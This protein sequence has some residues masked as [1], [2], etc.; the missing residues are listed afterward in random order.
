MRN[1]WMLA[2]A[3][4]LLFTACMV[5]GTA[6]PGP[7]DPSG[8]NYSG[9]SN[10]QAGTGIS[11]GMAGTTTTGATGGSPAVGSAGSSSAFRCAGRW[12]KQRTRRSP[13]C[14]STRVGGK[15]GVAE[16]TDL[17]WISISTKHRHYP[18]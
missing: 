7:P 14:A 2:G 13:K 1:V 11:S 8:T 9:N 18:I 10:G 17:R 4:T 12:A 15:A 6:Q 5:D 16:F 3:G